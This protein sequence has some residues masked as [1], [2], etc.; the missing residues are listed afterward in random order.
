MNIKLLATLTGL[1]LSFSVASAFATNTSANKPSGKWPGKSLVGYITAYGST[2]P[3][4]VTNQMVAESINNHYNVF[5]YAFGSINKQNNVSMPSGI[6]KI[7]FTDQ[8][9]NIH[10]NKGIALV[11][12]GGQNNTFL[13]N[14]DDAIQAADNTAAIL[15]QY[16]LDGIDLDLES[17]D[18]DSNYLEQYIGEL[19]NMNPN[20]ILTAA[21]Q[22]AG[23]YG[24]PA[25]LA[26]TSIFT[27]NFITNANFDALLI[28]EYNQYAGA[29]FDGKQDTD[30]GFIT[31]SFTPLTQIIPNR[32]KI[33]IGEPA[34]SSAGT[35]LSNPNLVLSDIQ[36]GG[37]LDNN[38]YG[39]I[40]TWALNYDYTQNWS[41]ANG[42]YSVI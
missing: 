2:I 41:F 16:N 8:I 33:I 23:G 9:N 36:S 11:S 29:V 40:M 4:N 24:G 31:A 13:P 3:P 39:G 7:D 35:G 14:P 42:V 27:Q 21:P 32:T 15:K 26:P 6:T 10:Q 37:V 12:F 1:S 25:Q 22:I 30:E 17:I 38:Q 5:V 20:I 19:R 28:Q 18:V 34:N